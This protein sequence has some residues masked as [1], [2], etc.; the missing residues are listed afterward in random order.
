MKQN[1]N[2]NKTGKKG[3]KE[4]DDNGLE[5]VSIGGNRRDGV[6][7][8]TRSLFLEN[9]SQREWLST[10]EAAHF[11]S[12]SSNALRIMVHRDQIRVFKFGRR[13]R[14]R[15]Q[16]CRQLFLTKGA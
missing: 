9:Q 2:D 15:V 16:D 13:L 1:D 3:E 7:F 8:E 14:F 6:G 4:F 11:L 12:I 5:A 10:E